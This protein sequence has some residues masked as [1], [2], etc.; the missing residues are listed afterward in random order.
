MGERASPARAPRSMRSS[1]TTRARRSSGDRRGACSAIG[2]QQYAARAGHHL[3]PQPLSSGRNVFEELGNGF[4]LIDLESRRDAAFEHAAPQL[5]VPL[6]V[7][8]DAAADGR[9]K[10]ESR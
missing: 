2:S 8:R 7:I 3:A 1:R 9:E 4:T 5:N 6:K 10:Y